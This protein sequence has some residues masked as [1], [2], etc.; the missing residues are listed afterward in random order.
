M[1]S[2]VIDP[3]DA[4][5]ILA[6]LVLTGA[7]VLALVAA[8][9]PADSENAKYLFGVIGV[10]LGLFGA[11]GLGSLLA[12]GV[13]SDAAEKAAP[14]AATAAANQVSGEVTQQVEEAL[15]APAAPSTR[16]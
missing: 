14:E 15:E 6:V 13:A 12:N 1:L 2:A 7:V 4:T 8:K 5:F 11:G 3:V 9:A 10:M 16:P